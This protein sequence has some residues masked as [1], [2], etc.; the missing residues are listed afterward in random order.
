MICLNSYFYCTDKKTET[1][2]K[3][4]KCLRGLL[5]TK[6]KLILS[7]NQ[8][9]FWHKVLNFSNINFNCF[10]PYKSYLYLSYNK[11]DM[12]QMPVLLPLKGI[13][14]C[15][16]LL[17][18]STA[19]VLGHRCYTIRSRVKWNQL[20]T[21]AKEMRTGFPFDSDKYCSH[22]QRWSQAMSLLSNICSLHEI[23]S[24]APMSPFLVFIF[25]FWVKK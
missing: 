1:L 20:W 25:C 23:K 6:I 15:P 12:P 5:R 14:N 24:L 2:R 9:L 7:Q 21:L 11:T 8:Y 18:H 3:P 10:L 13:S 16:A 17:P 22:M 4:R 19:A